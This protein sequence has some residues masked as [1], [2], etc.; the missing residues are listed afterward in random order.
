MN[1]RLYQVFSALRGVDPRARYLAYLML[2]RE[3][4]GEGEVWQGGVAKLAEAV[5]YS[6]AGVSQGLKAL[7]GRGVLVKAKKKTLG[8]P[9]ETYRLSIRFRARESLAFSEMLCLRILNSESK[10]F[11]QL[12]VVERC[13]LAQLWVA[14]GD[15]SGQPSTIA[16]EGASALIRVGAATLAEEV[17]LHESTVRRL[18]STLGDNH[19]IC[20]LNPGFPK[21][22]ILSKENVYFLLGSSTVSDFPAGHISRID[23]SGVLGWFVGSSD[24][25]LLREVRGIM[26]K[27]ALLQMLKIEDEAAKRY[28]FICLCAALSNKVVAR[29]GGLKDFIVAVLREILEV[30]EIMPAQRNLDGPMRGGSSL[31]ELM[32]SFLV[33][34]AHHLENEILDVLSGI[35]SSEG[36]SLLGLCCFPVRFGS[37]FQLQIN[38]IH[39]PCASLEE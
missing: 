12:S 30:D 2:E 17:G 6:K 22:K 37:A 10:V 34:V 11:G 3:L 26:P 9:V 1:A 21:G 38:S 25:G 13:L 31:K 35:Y 19:F 20:C 15:M 27:S 7:V 14:L 8:R 36:D 18:L 23:L 24:S 4:V 33:R 16:R 32:E 29:G 28:F 39:H 5:G